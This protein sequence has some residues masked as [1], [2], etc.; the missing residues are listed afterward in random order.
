[1]GER[2]AGVLRWVGAPRRAADPTT[3]FPDSCDVNLERAPV[4]LRIGPALAQPP[5]GTKPAGGG[6]GW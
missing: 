1:M 3:F 6:P 5:V 2:G 4:R